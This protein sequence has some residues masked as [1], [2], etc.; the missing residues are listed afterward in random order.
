LEEGD[1]M[2]SLLLDVLPYALIAALPSVYVA[3]FTALI[4]TNAKRPILGVCAFTA[5]PLVLDAILAA[6]VLTVFWGEGAQGSGG[7]KVSAWI[8]IVLGIF[9]IALGLGAVFETPS[10][11]KDAGTR[12][13][14]EKAAASS[15]MALF[16]I[17]VVTQII[18]L[19]SLAIF[20]S[21]LKEIVVD[22][23][24]VW[25]AVVAVAVMLAIMLVPYY[26]PAVYFALNRQRATDV[27]GRLSEWLIRHNRAIEIGAGLALGVPFLLKGLAAL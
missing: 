20:G 22:P 14:I 4:L 10:P 2:G 15:L 9:L 26:G 1:H 12:A 27:L 5:G 7:A 13:K 17:G 24:P 19:D 11:E 3:A 16:A 23:V 8:D 21:G 6:V 25:Q 18:D